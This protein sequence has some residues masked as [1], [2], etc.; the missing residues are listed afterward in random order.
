[1]Q[2]L[3]SGYVKHNPYTWIIVAPETIKLRHF[4][5]RQKNHWPLFP[6]ISILCEGHIV[7]DRLIIAAKVHCYCCFTIDLILIL[8]LYFFK[9]KNVIQSKIRWYYCSINSHLLKI[10]KSVHTHNTCNKQGCQF[11]LAELWN[12]NPH[13]HFCW[14]AQRCFVALH[15]ASILWNIGLLHSVW[16]S[17]STV[18]LKATNLNNWYNWKTK[19]HV[20]LQHICHFFRN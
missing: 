18:Y 17:V 10:C 7:Q 12:L 4:V 3:S 15:I 20:L 16:L 13:M 14:L 8:L 1:M 6:P 9:N 2:R 5:F 19:S 11:V